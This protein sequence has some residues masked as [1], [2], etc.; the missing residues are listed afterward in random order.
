MRRALGLAFMVCLS[1]PSIQ[2]S[3]EKVN[4][5]ELAQCHLDFCVTLK[6]DRLY[7]SALSRSYAFGPSQVVIT[8]KDQSPVE[9]KEFEGT[10]NASEGRFYLSNS[11]LTY[12]V[13]IDTQK[14]KI[15]RLTRS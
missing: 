14:R 5:V 13:V 3:P 2:A 12:D 4:Q 6:T 9:L 15:Y 8:E 11:N 10:F 1:H 7:K